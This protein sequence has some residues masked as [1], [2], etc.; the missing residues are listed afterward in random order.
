M[1]GAR[2]RIVRAGGLVTL[3]DDGRNGYRRT[4]VSVSGPMD[5]I[6]HE[7]ALRLAGAEPDEPAFEVGPGGLVVE[8]LD[9][10]VRL[11]V[12][13]P[14][15]RAEIARNDAPRAIVPAPAR[16]TLQP[17][18]T[19]T[20]RAGGEGV[21]GTLA[22]AGLDAGPA[23][24]GSRATNAR[25]GLGPARPEAG[26]KYGCDAAEPFP[27]LPYLD[28][29]EPLR[30]EPIRVL[31]GP[32]AHLFASDMLE[33]LVAETYRVT[34]QADRMGYRLDGPPLEA[35]THD[36]V[37]DALVKG[38][39]QVPGDGRPIV[40]AADC[41]P[42]GGYPKIA[43]VSR[44]DLPRLVQRR[45]GDPVSFRWAGEAEAAKASA[46]L[47]AAI[48]AP[49]PRRRTPNAPPFLASVSKRRP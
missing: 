30:G 1:S 19:L 11:G 35:S 16:I 14:G 38:A 8:P 36:I 49:E 47:E 12:A 26:A 2:L 17:G 10:P 15:H 37:S 48:R 31:P 29:L 4:G 9:A 24:L 27:P 3:Q 45:A 21:W 6:A 18:E 33:R 23:M 43:V 41:A 22:V 44:A 5:W 20:L 42:T 25:T 40:L 13:G 39:M 34:A 32:Q 7:L 28:P 46:A